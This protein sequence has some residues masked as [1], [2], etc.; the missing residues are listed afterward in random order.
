MSDKHTTQRQ[1]IVFDADDGDYTGYWFGERVP[2]TFGSYLEAEAPSTPMSE[3][4]SRGSL[5]CG[6]RR[7]CA[8]RPCMKVLNSIQAV[9]DLLALAEEIGQTEGLDARAAFKRALAELPR[10]ANDVTTN[11]RYAPTTPQKPVT[12]WRPVQRERS[13]R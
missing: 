12:R 2:G 7:G 6:R 8:R 10:L 11:V 13:G 9:A 5:P 1:F 3:N 4:S